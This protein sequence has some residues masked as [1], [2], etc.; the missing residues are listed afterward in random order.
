MKKQKGFTL[1][2]LLVVI[3]IISVLLTMLTP[4][5]KMARDHAKMANCSGNLKA[6][7]MGFI[8]YL[9]NYN[10]RF[11]RS[12]N[13]GKWDDIGWGTTNTGKPLLP[14]PTYAISSN[15]VYW[16]IA[17]NE[18]I[19]DRETFRCPAAIRPSD[20]WLPE[21]QYL[22]KNSSYGLNCYVSG[23]RLAAFQHPEEAIFCQDHLVHLLD[24]NGDMLYYHQKSKMNMPQLRIDF[25]P[26]YPD[27]EQEVFRHKYQH[28]GE[29]LFSNEKGLGYCN[30][31]WLD[32]HVEAISGGASD[33]GW[34]VPYRWYNPW[35]KSPYDN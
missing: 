12:P 17:Y 8:M 29:A 4:A 15:L 27:G 24:D 11:H 25:A 2:E 3:A 14:D 9:D 5:L 7:G 13:G 23:R 6:V 1:V 30:T 16:G 22:Y 34:D 21:E 26:W 32:G 19:G 35:G 20:W 33:F 18:F 10:E 28:Q 31:L